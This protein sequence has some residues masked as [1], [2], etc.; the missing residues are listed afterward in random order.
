MVSLVRKTPIVRTVDSRAVSKRVVRRTIVKSLGIAPTCGF[1]IYD[2]LRVTSYVGGH[3]SVA[4]LPVV[5]P[6]ASNVEKIE[7][8]IGSSPLFDVQS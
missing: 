4:W 1:W 3:V 7:L 8:T 2:H 5:F 6:A